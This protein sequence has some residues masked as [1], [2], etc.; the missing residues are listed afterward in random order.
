MLVGLNSFNG[1]QTVHYLCL[2][3]FVLFIEFVVAVLLSFFPPACFL[4]VF[5]SVL[6]MPN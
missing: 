5:F 3:G 6:H 4:N 1:M 2:L